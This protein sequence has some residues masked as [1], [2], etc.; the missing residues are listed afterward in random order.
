MLG[1]PGLDGTGE[2]EG[3]GELGLRGSWNRYIRASSCQKCSWDT[4]MCDHPSVSSGSAPTVESSLA[5][6]PMRSS[7]CMTN[8][9]FKMPSRLMFMRHCPFGLPSSAVFADSG[10]TNLMS[11][12]G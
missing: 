5:S 3:N 1:E 10:V 8:L 9:L 12:S 2:E 7:F 4:N 11:G 6:R